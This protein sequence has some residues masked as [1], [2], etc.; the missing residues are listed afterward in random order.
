[1]LMPFYT[2]VTASMTIGTGAAI[3]VCRAQFF[4][5]SIFRIGVCET[6]QIGAEENLRFAADRLEQPVP[7][8]RLSAVSTEALKV[9]VTHSVDCPTAALAE[10][11]T[12]ISFVSVAASPAEIAFAI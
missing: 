9:C 10:A 1:M 8:N 2:R 3:W 11:P 7:R 4:G 12:P 5:C 6:T